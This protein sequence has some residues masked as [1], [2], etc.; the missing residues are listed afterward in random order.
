[1]EGFEWDDEKDATNRE[2]H[3][4]SFRNA[5]GAFFD[6]FN[7][8]IPDPDHSIGEE[9]FILLG[10]SAGKVLVVSFTE[11]ESSIRI[12]SCRKANS[13]ERRFYEQSNQQ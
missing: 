2:K 3:G 11:R 7:I 1:M 9:R 13:A 5:S 10:F 6:P 4:V 12:I 8:K